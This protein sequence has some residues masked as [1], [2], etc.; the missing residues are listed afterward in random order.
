[1]H[2]AQEHLP[3][4]PHRIRRVQRKAVFSYSYSVQSAC[5]HSSADPSSPPV[6]APPSSPP[7]HHTQSPPVHQSCPPPF[8]AVSRHHFG[9]HHSSL[10][11]RL[12]T[13]RPAVPIFEALIGRA[14]GGLNY[15]SPKGATTPHHLTRKKGCN[16]FRNNPP[17]D[18]IFAC[19]PCRTQQPVRRFLAFGKLLQVRCTV[20]H[21]RRCSYSS[22]ASATH[23]SDC[24]GYPTTWIFTDVTLK[25][26]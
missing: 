13:F 24:L 18:S 8:L 10:H 12:E 11:T 2:K 6:S 16:L 23:P 17:C 26:N 22:R 1:M 4:S 7:A 14:T 25:A 21:P 19:F 9:C 15:C 5:R 3:Q 20:H